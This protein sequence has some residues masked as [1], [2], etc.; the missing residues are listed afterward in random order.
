MNK[1]WVI[2]WTGDDG[3]V[4]YRLSNGSYDEAGWN[5][6]FYIEDA[7]V[8]TTR[9]YASRSLRWCEAGAEIVPV[10]VAYH[11]YETEEDE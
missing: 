1:G 8:F 9:G 3:L 6:T 5:S 10:N 7:T 11:I 2:R 4:R